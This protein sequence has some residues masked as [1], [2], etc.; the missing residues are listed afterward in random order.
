[1]KFLEAMGSGVIVELFIAFSK[2]HVPGLDPGIGIG[3]RKENTQ[4]KLEF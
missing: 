2:T 3:S 4:T 1:M